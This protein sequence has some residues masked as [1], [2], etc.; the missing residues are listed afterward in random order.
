MA[1]EEQAQTNGEG[2]QPLSPARRKRLQQ[3]F[4]HASKQAAQQN[5]DYATEL[6]TQCVVG[7]PDNLV[8]VQSF[9]DNLVKKYNNNKTGSKLA[10]FKAGKD[11]ASLKKAKLQQNWNAILVHGLEV[12]KVNPWDVPTLTAMAAA[13]EEMNFD[14]TP[15]F[16]LKCALETNSKDPEVNRLCAIALRLRSQFD[17]AIACWH[18]VEQALP[19]DEE[20]QRA[21]ADLAVEKTIA[22]GGYSEAESAQDVKAGTVHRGHTSGKGREVQEKEEE[23]PEAGLEKQI[24]EDP[25][26]ISAY[27]QLA[28]IF[29]KREDH[30]KATEVIKRACKESGNDPEIVE[31]LHDS[32]LQ[33]L[34]QKYSQLE[35]QYDGTADKETKAKLKKVRKEINDKEILLYESRSSR[36]GNNMALKFE[37]GLRYQIAGRHNDAIKQFQQAR[38]DPRRKGLCMLALGQCF[39]HIKQYRLAST[40]YKEAIENIPDRDADNKKEA[41]YLAGRLAVQMNESGAGEKYLTALAGLDFAYKDVSELLD[42]LDS[43]RNNTGS[44]GGK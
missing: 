37:L 10:R 21:I 9:I 30:A 16:Y 23:R 42:K 33:G 15:L 36:F 24:K 3:C 20:A 41:L 2:R 22:K 12:L 43:L 18:R 31:R 35:K 6:F 7:D 38:N 11:R 8:Y 27:L 25:K 1:S 19:N 28:E 44:E 39:Q 40:H 34:R 5:Y 13:G 14:E 29:S 4:E 26:N 32:Q 17:Q